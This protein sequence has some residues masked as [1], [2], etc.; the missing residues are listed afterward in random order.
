VLSPY[1]ILKVRARFLSGDYAQA[2]AAAEVVEADAR[3]PLTTS[4]VRLDYHFYTALTIAALFDRATDD[5]RTVWRESLEAH[6]AQLRE[7]AEV[8]PLTFGDKYAL[9]A[10]EIARIEGRDAEAM[11]FYEQAI[12]LARE[13]GFLQHEALAYELAA[14]FYAARKLETIAQ[15]YQRAARRC[16]LRWGAEGKVRQLEQLYPHLREAPIPSG[17]PRRLIDVCVTTLGAPASLL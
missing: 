14:R 10:A 17:S 9:V 5:A 7:W 11:Q 2:L 13:H 12:Q 3:S 6:Q 4:M 8:N 1:W 15:A 16:Y